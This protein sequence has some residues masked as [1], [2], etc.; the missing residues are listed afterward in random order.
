MEPI[1]PTKISDSTLLFPYKKQW[2]WFLFFQI[3]IAVF[4]SLELWIPLSIVLL[5][6]LLL[7]SLFDI[8]SSIYFLIIS[9]FIGI[10]ILKEPYGIRPVDVLIIFTIFAYLLHKIYHLDYSFSFNELSRPVFIFLAAIFFSL[11]DAPIFQKGLINFFKHLELFLIFFILADLFNSWSLDRLRRLIEYFIYVAV[12]ATLIAL[13]FL[14]FGEN[15]RAFGVTGTSLSDLTVS[16]LIASISFLLLSNNRRRTRKFLALASLLFIGL[17]MTQTRGAWLGFSVSFLFLSYLLLKKSVPGTTKKLYQ[18]FFLGLIL[19]IILFFVF[20]TAFVGI[21]HRVEQIRYVEV[22]T[23]Q[24]RLILWHAAIT[25]FWANPINGI[26]LGQFSLLSNKYSDIG[27]TELFKENIEGLTAHNVFISYLSET[28][29]I[30]ILA[31]IFLYYSITRIAAKNFNRIDSDENLDLVI[32]LRTF[33]FFVVISSTYAGSWFWGLNGTQFM[34][35][36]A[37]SAAVSKKV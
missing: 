1:I 29:M 18:L 30:G 37:I 5:V 28:G 13:T 33:F 26:G 36:L 22:G 20:E 12:A 11:I 9:L 4:F 16:A 6:P 19:I 31:L 10:F 3:L 21:S 24:F 14:L 34:I 35:F 15:S 17:V 8:Q 27:D 2:L 23:I 32:I 25:A 7:F